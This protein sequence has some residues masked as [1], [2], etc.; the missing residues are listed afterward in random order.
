[1]NKQAISNE[2]MEFLLNKG[3]ELTIQGL[4][5]DEVKEMIYNASENGIMALCESLEKS[6]KKDISINMTDYQV[7]NAWEFLNARAMNLLT[8]FLFEMISDE[9]KH[10]LM[11]EKTELVSFFAHITDEVVDDSLTE[12]QLELL[13]THLTSGM[14]S[15]YKCFGH[16][17]NINLDIKSITQKQW[18][19]ESGHLNE[20]S[21]NE[22]SEI[23]IYEIMVNQSK[24]HM[25]HL[26]DLAFMEDTYSKIETLEE[27]F[28]YEDLVEPTKVMQQN[29]P[30]TREN[31]SIK[32]PQFANF[33]EE[34]YDQGQHNLGLLYDVPLELSVVLGKTKM[35][36][37]D[38]LEI[39]TGKIIELNKYADDPLEIYANGKLIAEGEVVVV[40]ENFGVRVTKLHHNEFQIK[41]GKR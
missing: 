27:E 11:F 33:S 8:V 9:G 28:F 16:H 38:V 41:G 35:S 24:V 32:K 5:N 21:L 6:F 22:M 20:Y 29:T 40:D 36:V 34:I 7:A 39:N 17:L 10:V 2:E 37:K 14:K 25:V 4:L 15:Y 19:M 26:S 31:E 23:K 13:M 12:T 3:K 18:D 30:M 1:M